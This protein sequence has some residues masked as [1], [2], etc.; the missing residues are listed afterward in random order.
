[1]LH[2]KC[3]ILFLLNHKKNCPYHGSAKGRFPGWGFE[4]NGFGAGF[5]VALRVP[6]PGEN[7]DI[8]YVF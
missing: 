3:M 2:I 7:P 8:N 4:T 1:M 6:R 5:Q